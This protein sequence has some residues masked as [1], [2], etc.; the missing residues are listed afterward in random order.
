MV[1]S[2]AALAAGGNDDL[3]AIV[4]NFNEDFTGLGILDNRTQWH[5]DVRVLSVCTVLVLASARFTVLS[6][7]VAGVLE[8]QQR[9]ILGI[10]SNDDVP[11]ASTVTAV[12]AALRRHPVAHEMRRA[13]AALPRAAANLDVINEVLARHAWGQWFGIAACKRSVI[14]SMVPMPSTPVNFPWAA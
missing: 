4:K 14:S 9:P 11:S 7:D 8:V 10:A 12:G 13:G 1:V 3:L 5:I 2:E 6:D